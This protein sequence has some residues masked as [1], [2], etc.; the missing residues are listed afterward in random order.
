MPCSSIVGTI[1]VSVATLAHVLMITWNFV[2]MGLGGQVSGWVQLAILLIPTTLAGSL[3]G[4]R[5]YQLN[6][7]RQG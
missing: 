6:S 1:G 2:W 4:M 7:K 5:V 3:T